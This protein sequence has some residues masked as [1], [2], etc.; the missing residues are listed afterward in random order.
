MLMCVSFN[1]VGFWLALVWE[2]R[3]DP[4]ATHGNSP[5]PT[6]VN[7]YS[8]QSISVSVH[9]DR[10]CL[11]IEY[12]GVSYVILKALLL[13]KLSSCLFKQHEDLASMERDYTQNEK[14]GFKP[15]S[16]NE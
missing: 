9:R 3:D 5:A 4:K 6:P 16:V 13:S 15:A 14:N 2:K 7:P 1:F 8:S 11:E 12:G 10:T